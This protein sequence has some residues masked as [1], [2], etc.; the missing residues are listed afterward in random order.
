MIGFQTASI[1]F[2]F[3]TYCLAFTFFLFVSIQSRV[4][5]SN[6]NTFC[7]SSSLIFRPLSIKRDL[8]VSNNEFNSF[9]ATSGV[10]FGGPFSRLHVSGN[11]A[12][13]G[14]CASYHPKSIFLYPFI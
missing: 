3:F 1:A 10:F 5:C 14:V 12:S 6:T 7:L 2:F 11:P 13:H 4:C 9:L 8:T